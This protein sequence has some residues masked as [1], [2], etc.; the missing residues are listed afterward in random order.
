MSGLVAASTAVAGSRK[1]VSPKPCSDSNAGQFRLASLVQY[2]PLPTVGGYLGY[3]RPPQLRVHCLLRT[4]G[5]YE[6]SGQYEA[7]KSRVNVPRRSCEKNKAISRVCLGS[8][9]L[10]VSALPA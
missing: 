9:V 1:D 8:F 3:V 5:Q 2:V 6:V 4:S 7:M 10:H